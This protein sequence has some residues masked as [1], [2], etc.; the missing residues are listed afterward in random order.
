MF[1]P[2]KKGFKVTELPT[3][4]KSVQKPKRMV[5]KPKHLETYHL[6]PSIVASKKVEKIKNNVVMG[7]FNLDTSDGSLSPFADDIGSPIMNQ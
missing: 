6:E 5:K 2:K 4:P 1:T 7:S 3:P